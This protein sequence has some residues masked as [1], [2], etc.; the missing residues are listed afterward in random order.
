MNSAFLFTDRSGNPSPL[1]MQ[2]DKANNIAESYGI[3]QIL[4]KYR[5]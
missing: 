4:Q 1:Q 5:A 2:K 3:W